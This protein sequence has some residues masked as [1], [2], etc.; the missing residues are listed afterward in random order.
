[1]RKMNKKT[2]LG[3]FSVKEKDDRLQ[4]EVYVLAARAGGTTSV[5]DTKECYKKSIEVS[6]KFPSLQA[7]YLLE[8][9][10]WMFYYGISD[11]QNQPA[12]L[13]QVS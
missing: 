12:Q 10:E 8:Y 7:I 4:A 1:M 5:E 2:S 9:A 13:I 11:P 3:M 6:Q